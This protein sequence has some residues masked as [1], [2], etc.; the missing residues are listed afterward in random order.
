MTPTLKSLWDELHKGKVYECSIR[1]KTDHL[2]GFWEGDSI[3]VDPRFGLCEILIH[4]LLHRNQP[5]MSEQSVKRHAHRLVMTMSD[6]TKTKW[7]TAYNR[8]KIKRR[9]KDYPL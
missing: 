3:Y 7:W 8:L 1:N 9:P 5:T 2:Y 4:E 6:S